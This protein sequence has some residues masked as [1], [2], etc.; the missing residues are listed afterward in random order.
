MRNG[1]LLLFGLVVVI[2]YGISRS[3]KKSSSS[4]STELMASG[5]EPRQTSYQSP[6]PGVKEFFASHPHFGTI[7]DANSM[8]NWAQ[9]ARQQIG[10]DS[11]DYL[12][13]LKV[14]TVVTLYQNDA[15]GRRELWRRRE[16]RR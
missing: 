13:Y 6:L 4:A 7:L 16:P 8:P 9:G 3:S 10:T 1:R 11:G 5:D 14:D 15:S 12:V 2:A